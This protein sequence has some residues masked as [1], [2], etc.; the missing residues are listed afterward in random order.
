MVMQVVSGWWAVVGGRRATQRRRAGKGVTTGAKGGGWDYSAHIESQAGPATVQGWRECGGGEEEEDEMGWDERERE[1]TRAQQG[2]AR[3]VK[4]RFGESIGGW[5][6]TT[7]ERAGGGGCDRSHG[8]QRRRLRLDHM[9]PGSDDAHDA[10]RGREH[11]HTRCTLFVGPGLAF[12][13]CK[14]KPYEC[15]LP[16]TSSCRPAKPGSSILA[17]CPCLLHGRGSRSP[18]TNQTHFSLRVCQSVCLSPSLSLKQE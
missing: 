7:L 4:A 13:L 17:H 5:R 10:R 3:R 6:M 2:T 14:H 9:L 15:T 18:K 8:R 12:P 16:L 11:C 1:S